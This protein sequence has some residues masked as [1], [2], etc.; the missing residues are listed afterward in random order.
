MEEDVEDIL[1][2]E[3]MEEGKDTSSEKDKEKN[4][5]IL[6][7]EKQKIEKEIKEEE[8]D[9]EEEEIKEEEI[10][11]EEIE[12][13]EEEIEEEGIEEEEIEEEE[14][15]EEIEEEE[16][17][18]EIE[19]KELREEE[20]MEIEGDIEEEKDNG[21]DKK[22]KDDEEKI[23]G[24]SVKHLQLRKVA[25]ENYR[26]NA[27]RMQLKY[28]KA[29][30]KKVLTFSP[31]DCV[32][33]R[34]PR[35]DRS[36]TDA[37]RLPCVVVQR[38][39]IKFHLYR[40]RCSYGVL[41]QCYGEGDL[42]L[43]KGELNVPLNGWKN[44]PL[45]SL[46][47]AAF[48]F[49]PSNDFFVGLCNCKSVCSTKRCPCKRLKATCSSK[50][51]K[52]KQCAN[53][54]P[55]KKQPDHQKIT[56]FCESKPKK[57]KITQVND[58]DEYI[59]KKLLPCKKNKSKLFNLTQADIESLND[60]K[61]LNDNHI[62]AAQHLLQKQFP[63]IGGLQEPLLS[64]KMQW[65]L[66]PQGAVQLLHIN[67]NHWVCLSTIDCPIDTVRLYDSMNNNTISLAVQKQLS[68]LIYPAS[69][70]LT[71]EIMESQL[72]EGCSDCGLFAIAN[73]FMLCNGVGPSSTH[74]YQDKM[75]EHLVA[76]FKSKNFMTFPG[77]KIAKAEKVMQ[78]KKIAV[79][80]H[81]RQPHERIRK[82]ASCKLCQ[83]WY[84]TTC[85]EIPKVVSTSKQPFFCSSCK[86]T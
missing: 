16:F 40:L 35:I 49:N 75:R 36:S 22:N 26:R 70:F 50:C 18:E 25:D 52:G 73:A 86:N 59:S 57:R 27:E 80:C 11:E 60:G 32:S 37:H 78:V 82:M 61:W 9:I 58:S 67:G 41:S 31:G 81:C 56:A 63:N 64:Y 2:E 68:K 6:Y 34:I 39:G 7:N 5:K 69:K 10:E 66:M 14:F 17:L 42:E 62:R 38:H 77:K 1:N 47:E 46:R 19:E 28:A 44:A 20:E 55:S 29:K 65:E 84:H 53:C 21:N 24:T 13:E 71:V 43:F 45:I 85:E 12:E 54:V 48:K 3:E 4:Q 76:S 30:R 33:L 83:E 23:F 8:I 74:W 51:H 79:F 72:Q 15:E